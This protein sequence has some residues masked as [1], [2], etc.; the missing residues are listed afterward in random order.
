MPL[1]STLCGPVDRSRGIRARMRSACC[2]RCY[3][4]LKLLVASLF[5]MFP[6]FGLHTKRMMHLLS[7]KITSLR[8]RSLWLTAR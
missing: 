8:Y 3:G 1:L 6:R 4:V 2:L 7:F 5:E